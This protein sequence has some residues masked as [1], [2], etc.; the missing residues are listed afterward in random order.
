MK[1][2]HIRGDIARVLAEGACGFIQQEKYETAGNT[3]RYIR[4]SSAVFVIKGRLDLCST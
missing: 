4:L 3:A 2:F 1:I